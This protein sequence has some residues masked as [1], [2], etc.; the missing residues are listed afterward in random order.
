MGLPVKQKEELKDEFDKCKRLSKWNEIHVAF[1]DFNN[2]KQI[3][4]DPGLGHD[5]GDFVLEKVCLIIKNNLRYQDELVRNGGDE[6]VILLPKCNEAVAR[7]VINRISDAVSTDQTLI[8][9]LGE[10]FTVSIGC[11]RYD[12]K[13]HSDYK[14]AIKDTD[15]LMYAAKRGGGPLYVVYSNDP[16]NYKEDTI[17]QK[18]DKTP[19]GV[20]CRKKFNYMFDFLITYRY[21]RAMLVEVLRLM[22]NSLGSKVLD[23]SENELS[24][25][26]T[27]N[28][29]AFFDQQMKNKG[30]K[31]AK[32][33]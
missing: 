16:D 1:I 10:P 6:F 9:L 5:V 25:L 4:D 31:N 22:W 13:R 29:R 15:I 11:T 33:K 14:K 8:E 12:P 18:R 23:M 32:D 28:Y 7:E 26:I 2:F 24:D 20:L 3:N 17:N 27:R 19:A 30:S 21:D